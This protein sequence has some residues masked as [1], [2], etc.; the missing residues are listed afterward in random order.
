MLQDEHGHCVSYLLWALWAAPD[1]AALTAGAALARSWSE[2]VLDPLRAARRAA[3]AAFPGIDDVARL[4][5]REQVKGSEFQAERL[6]LEGLARIAG[7]RVVAAAD[8]LAL[9]TA[10]GEAWDGGKSQ[11][12]VFEPLARA[13]SA[14]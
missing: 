1:A 13:F 7:P 8:P 14:A 12:S 5:L 10:A 4:A 2:A 3:K 11:V 9:L 6:M